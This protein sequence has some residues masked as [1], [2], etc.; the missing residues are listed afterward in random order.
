MRLLYASR[1]QRMTP[2]SIRRLWTMYAD[3]MFRDNTIATSKGGRMFSRTL[4]HGAFYAGP[5][6]T[7]KVLAHMLERGNIEQLHRTIERQ[8]KQIQG[9]APRKRRH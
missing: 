3:I 4:A 9:Y 2:L 5:R 8:G 7:L 6:S 1:G